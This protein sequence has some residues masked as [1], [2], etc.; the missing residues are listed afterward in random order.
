MGGRFGAWWGRRDL[1]DILVVLFIAACLV[2]ILVNLSMYPVY[3]DIP[4]HMA[5]AE[6]FREAGGVLTWDFWDYAPQ[7]RPHIYP[8]LLHV[9][10][11]VMLDI[12][13]S[14]EFVATMVCVAMFPL[15]LLSL[16]WA[17]RK[18][19]GSRAAFYAVLLLGVPYVFFW[20]SGVT[21]AASLVLALT[22]MVFWALEEDRKVACT[23]LL[24]LCLYSHLV[25]G[26]LVALALFLYL[27]HRRQAWR[28]ILTVLGAAYL[29]YL[30]W[31]INVLANLSSFSVSEPAAGGGLILH[32]LLW[33]LAAAG[34]VLCYIR[35]KRYYLLAAYLLS[36]VPIAFFYSHRFWQGHI[37]LPLAML[38][39]V[40]LDGLH[41]ALR[42]YLSGREATASFARALSG[43]ALALLLLLVLCVDPVLAYGSSGPPG[44][45]IRNGDASG[46][47]PAAPKRP[48]GEGAAPPMPLPQP[49]LEKAPDASPYP[50]GAPGAPPA[51]FSRQGDAER[52]RP[53]LNRLREL[54]DSSLTLDLQPTTLLVLL[55][56][57]APSTHARADR[58]V[59]GEENRALMSAIELYSE[60]GDVVFTADGRLGDL[61]YAMTGRY[62]ARGMF[63]EVQPEEE[64]SPF[65]GARLA[66]MPADGYRGEMMDRAQVRSLAEEAGWVEVDRVGGYVI[67]LRQEAEGGSGAASAALP[68]WAAYVLLLA[69]LGAVLVSVFRPG[70][71]GSGPPPPPQSPRQVFR[72]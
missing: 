42:K 55:G 1:Y 21:V 52:R 47:P 24:A 45:G 72:S 64:S 29:L 39:A 9:A 41:A 67:Y 65:S 7:G 60:P 36:M 33:G 66:V 18:L 58:P 16:W 12:G 71:G 63:N 13:F 46:V 69:A 15:I 17:M 11:S 49:P 14:V 25:M 8:P 4:Y 31:G 70:P 27:L 32:I 51:P 26:H 59:F 40:A 62:A 68:L 3:L 48:P 28:K 44:G 50:G 23:I 54:G 30:P 57:E 5:V 19:F 56:W 2:L 34:F 6:G 35:R 20:Q 38:G 37:F 22:P 53:L 10:M 43:A 61:V